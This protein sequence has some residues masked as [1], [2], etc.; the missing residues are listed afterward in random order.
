MLK[1]ASKILIHY[2]EECS[3]KI[4]H[5]RDADKDLQYYVDA[6]KDVKKRKNKKRKLQN[7][8]AFA[9]FHQVFIE[10]SICK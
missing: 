3:G 7:K 4:L 2:V 9:F 6:L 8:Y 1:D 10:L 5:I